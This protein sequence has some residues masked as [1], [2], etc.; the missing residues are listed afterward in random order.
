MLSLKR[1][2]HMKILAVVTGKRTAL[3]NNEHGMYFSTVFFTETTV[4]CLSNVFGQVKFL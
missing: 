1:R 2:Q 4:M 3:H